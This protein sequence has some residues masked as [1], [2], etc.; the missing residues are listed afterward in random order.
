MSNRYEM[1]NSFA[2]DNAELVVGGEDVWV[3][4]DSIREG[5]LALLMAAGSQV[6]VIADQA[7]LLEEALLDTYIKVVKQK[8]IASTQEVVHPA[9]DQ[10]TTSYYEKQ[11]TIARL[12][13]ATPAR[14][15]L[16]SID[17]PNAMFTGPFK[18][19]WGDDRLAW[20]VYEGP[21]ATQVTIDGHTFDVW[22]ESIRQAWEILDANS[23]LPRCDRCRG[24]WGERLDCERCCWDN[25]FPRMISDPG[26]LVG[27]WADGTDEQPYPPYDQGWRDA[28]TA[29]EAPRRT[30]ADRD[31]E[32]TVKV[33]CQTREQ[34]EKAML[35]RMDFEQELGFNYLLKYGPV[36]HHS[37]KPVYNP[38]NGTWEASCTLCGQAFNPAHELDLVH[39]DCPVVS[40]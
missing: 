31:Y 21:D 17:V 20:L 39:L 6:T 2:L 12:A 28:I 26:P 35:E 29:W 33:T 9:A 15:S 40:K 13:L 32:F 3:G 14:A 1:F 10:R 11:G 8:V 7:D 5:E 25:G 38:A 34:A 4:E 18:D 36:D 19:Q 27:S 23:H 22:P 37:T 30:Q 24:K 16:L